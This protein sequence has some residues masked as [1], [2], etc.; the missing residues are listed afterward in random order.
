TLFRSSSCYRRVWLSPPAP[1]R[2]AARSTAWLSISPTLSSKNL[3]AP[4]IVRVRGSIGRL[5]LRP[6]EFLAHRDE[7]LSGAGVDAERLIEHPLRG[8]A[9]DRDRQPLND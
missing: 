3:A 9:F 4:E 1:C 6:H 5:L 2:P 8:A 7:F